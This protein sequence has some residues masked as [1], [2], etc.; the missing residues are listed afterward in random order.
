ML[1]KIIFSTTRLL[2]VGVL[3]GGSG[4]P[5]WAASQA[6]LPEVHATTPSPTWGVSFFG[7]LKYGPQFTHTAY[8]NP[9]APKGGQVQLEAIG[10]F[11]SLNPFLLKGT[12]AAGIAL[13]YDTLLA[14]AKDEPASAYGLVA[15]TVTLSPDRTQ[16]TFA[17]RPE[18]VW[19]DGTQITAY[20]V[21]FSFRILLQEGHPRYHTW[22]QEV[23]DVATPDS[24][25][26]VF[27]L[28]NPNNRELPLLLG[29]LPILSEAYFRQH[30]FPSSGRDMPVGSGPYR[31]HA[32]SWGRDITYQRN[33]H[34]WGRDLPINRGRYNFDTIRFI[35]YRDQTVATEA[36]KAGN[37]DFRV[38]NIAR[39][40]ARSYAIPARAEGRL[41]QEAI[42]NA[43][44]SGMQGFVFNTRRAPF[45]D[46]RVRQALTYLYDFTWANANLFYNAYTRNTSFFPNTAFASQG[47]PS[48][49]E[50][51]LLEP[52]RAQLP[53]ALWTT[54][55]TL[56]ETDGKGYDHTYR[57]QAYALLQEAGWELHDGVMRERA[58]GKPMTFTFLLSQP[59]YVRVLSAYIRNL[60]R[61]GIHAEI[62]MVDD[63]QYQQRLQQF[64]FDS[65]LYTFVHG[66]F[67][68]NEQYNYWHSQSAQTPGSLNLAGVTSPAIDALVAQVAQAPDAAQ[69]RTA[70]HAL[71][72]VLLWGFYV[73]PNWHI[74]HFRVAYWDVFG[75]RQD[76]PPLYDLA[77]LDTWWWDPAKAANVRKP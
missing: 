51:T 75:R 12:P 18:A 24:S 61:L 3:L 7:D 44:P 8:V 77:I 27:T 49:E 15:K 30:P 1:V 16:V 28:T 56:P 14:S 58:T 21:A 42:Q 59:A 6:A 67:P 10:T 37:L 38:E 36:L 35:Y 40:W 57:Q 41:K 50:R 70:V 34:Y 22:Y 33:P 71:D 26:V 25:T 46:R 53:S 62:R 52:W 17:L 32:V 47:L 13:V 64:D 4:M 2:C 66:A 23:K 65:V 63:G 20:D 5:A 72:R 74:P 76:A 48:A 9:D 43:V 69:H 45:H 19:P 60:E 11:D 55:F 68:G 39:S 29:Q 31:V 73:L 54:P